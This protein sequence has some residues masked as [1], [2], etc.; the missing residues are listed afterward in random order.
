[1]ALTLSFPFRAWLSHTH[2]LPPQPSPPPPPPGSLPGL[3]LVEIRNAW[4]FACVWLLNSTNQ[5]RMK[6]GLE[7]SSSGCFSTAPPPWCWARLKYVSS[8][9]HICRSTT[10]R[11]SLLDPTLLQLIWA[12]QEGLF[13]GLLSPVL[14]ENSAGPVYR[15]S[16][17]PGYPIKLFFLYP[18]CLIK[19]LFLSILNTEPSPSYFPSTCPDCLAINPYLS[20]LYLEFSISPLLP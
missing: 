7:R 1:M 16:S 6:I 15:E 5:N 4:L 13:L 12:P 17:H 14:T 18:W 3:M 11:D 19:F 2:P 20:L 10:D 9:T 8:F